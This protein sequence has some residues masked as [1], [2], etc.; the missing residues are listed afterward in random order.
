MA[1]LLLLAAGAVISLLGGHHLDQD[2]HDD[3][4][5]NCHPFLPPLFAEHPPS[6]SHPALLE[7]IDELHAKLSQRF[8]EL[9]IDSL[10]VAVVTSA[11][12][13]FEHNWGV[14]RANES[15]SGPVTSHSIYRI[16]S[17]SK[18]FAA[19]EGWVLHQKG[20]LSW[21]DPVRVYLPQFAYRLD[22][23]SES[24]PGP[25][26]D[27][28]PITISQLASHTSGIGRDWPP[29]TAV[30][31]PHTLEGGGPPPINGLPFPSEGQLFSAIASTR[32]TYPPA[33]YPMYSNTGTGL[34]GLTLVAANRLHGEPEE[35]DSYAALMKRDVFG[36]LGLNGSSFIASDANKD[37][38]VV[39]SE[40][41]DIVDMDF[42]DTMN[43]GGGQFASLSDFVKLSQTL[44]NPRRSDA[45]LSPYSVQR[46]LRP[47]FSFEEDHWTEAGLVW[48]ILRQED[49]NGRPRKIFWKLGSVASFNTVLSIHPGSG[50]GVSLLMSGRY[51]EAA[52]LAYEVFGIMQPAM[53]AALAEAAAQLY[54]GDWTSSD[55]GSSAHVVVNKGTLFV[56]VLILEGVDAL[57]TLGAKTGERFALRYAGRYDEFRIDMGRPEINGQKHMGCMSHW[58]GIDELPMLNGATVNTLYFSG[59]G[60]DRRLHI[61]SLKIVMSRRTQTW[62]YAPKDLLF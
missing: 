3:P 48:E 23:F 56:E 7:T 44:L 58:A 14:L 9:D 40:E 57:R 22:G 13:V 24:E 26:M 16:A 59:E 49:S 41:S 39:P 6:A 34:L 25:T 2:I 45:L 8:E 21:E 62:D 43:A 31:W 46:W 10:S 19:F 38:L 15:V 51:S 50:Y 28:Y 18:L 36:P 61:P 37:L 55:N 5:W 60:V 52:K 12:P 32:M 4:R 35:P 30:N 33:F 20:R 27:D 53:D 17:V 42:T 29:G 54:A 11:G 1:N 47:V